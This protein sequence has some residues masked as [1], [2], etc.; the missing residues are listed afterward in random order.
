L[1]SNGIESVLVGGA[2]VAIDTEGL[3]QSGDLPKFDH[4]HP[5]SKTVLQ[6]ACI[7]NHAITLIKPSW[8]ALGNLKK[9][10]GTR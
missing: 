6:D 2:V 1:E 10:I 9:S 8:Y 7:G 4:P 3:Y 5:A